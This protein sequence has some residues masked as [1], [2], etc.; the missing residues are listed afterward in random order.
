[1]IP[2]YFKVGFCI[3]ALTASLFYGWK[4]V[5][6]FLSLSP[7]RTDADLHRHKKKWSWQLHQFWLNFF[8][9]AVGWTCLWFVIVKVWADVACD[10]FPSLSWGESALALVAF[11]GVTGYLPF[12]A[13]NLA[14]TATSLIGKLSGVGKD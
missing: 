12:T 7:S 10:R 4:A 5:E 2:C 8:G 3:F 13:V 6:I 11:L 9:S 14:N 1:M